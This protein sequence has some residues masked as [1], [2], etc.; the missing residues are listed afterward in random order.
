MKLM[1]T[2]RGFTLVEMAVVLV[3]VGLMLGG[4]LM[5]ISAQME[6]RDRSNTKQRL[7]EIKEALIGFAIMNGR[8]PCPTTQADPSNANYGLEDASCTAPSPQGYIPWKTLGV[9]EF[10]AWGTARKTIAD[11]WVGY[12]RYRVDSNFSVAITSIT[13]GFSADALSIQDNAGNS[14][15]TSTERPIAVVF[16]TG[17]NLAANGENAD[18]EGTNGLYQSDVP[19]QT[20]DDQ[21]IWLSRPLLMNRMVMAG[22]LP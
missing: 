16:S 15:T 14:L 5:P 9:P 6:Q 21:L 13:T 4:I 10:D 8:L 3:I 22:Q 12:W 2:A 19:S 11:P 18:Y 1:L 17:K 7:E 20:F